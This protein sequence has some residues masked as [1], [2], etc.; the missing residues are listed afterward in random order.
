MRVYWY[1]NGN[2][3]KATGASIFAESEDSDIIEFKLPMA[4]VDSVVHATF[5]LPYP[6]NSEQFGH[7][8]AESLL[9]HVEEDEIDG[10]YVWRATIPGGY[11]VNNGT[12]YISARVESNDLLVVETTEQVQFEI[13][14]GGTYEATAVLPEQAEQINAHLAT[15]DATLLEIQG[16]ISDLEGEISTKQDKHDETLETTSKDVVGA[17]NGLNDDIRHAG[18]GILARLTAAETDIDNIEAEQVTQNAGIRANTDAIN[19]TAQTKG[20]LERVGDLENTAV[21]GET[22]IATKTGSALPTSQQL[23]A[24]VEEIAERDPKGGDYFYFIQQITGGTDKNYKYT[25][26]SVSGWSQAVEI[27]SIEPAGNDTLGIIKGNYTGDTTRNFQ[28]NVVNGEFQSVNVV[29]NDGTLREIRE[30]V[31]S[32]ESALADNIDQ[33]TTNKENIAQNT[34]DIETI[35]GEVDDILDGT[36]E[37]PKATKA[38]QDGN[39]NNIVDTYMTK[40]EGTTKQFVKDYAVP[41]IFN[42]VYF[43]SQNGYV[44]EVP[45]TPASGVQFSVTT[46]AVDDFVLFQIQHQN[47]A[48]FELSAKNSSQNNIFISANV[49]ANVYF[50][51]TT[52]ALVDNQ[53]KTLSIELS[54]LKQMVA[55]EIHKI[56]FSSSFIS[57]GSEVITFVDGAFIRQTLEVVTQSSATTTF[58]VYSNET[59]PSSFN[60]NIQSETLVVSEAATKVNINGIYTPVVNFTEDPQTQI[61]RNR[62]SITALET[63]K[64][65]VIDSTHKLSA[66]L[67]D[68]TNTT[69][70]FVTASDKTMWNGKQDALSTAQLAAVNS[71]ADATKI[72]QIATNAN[73]IDAIEALIPSQATANNQLA[74]KAFVNSTVQTGTANFRGNWVTWADVPTQASDYPLDY[75]QSRT[76]TVNDYL[77]VQDASGYP[78][79]TLEGT[80]RFK[81]SGDWTTNGKNGWHPEYQ[82]NET[83]FTS[84]QLDAINSGATSALIGQ[85]T[86]NQNAITGLGTSKQDVIDASHKLSA[87]LVDDTNT[88]NLFVTSSEKTTWSG[89]QDA[90]T[91]DSSP[92]QNSANPVT[93]GGVYTALAAKADDNAVVKLTGNQTVAG[94]KTFSSPIRGSLQYKDGGGEY[95]NLISGNG[96]NININEGDYEGI[97]DVKIWGKNLFFND[98]CIGDTYHK[99]STPKSA[100]TTSA[101]TTTWNVSDIIPAADYVSGAVYELYGQW[102]M[103]KSDAAFGYIWTDLWGN[104]TPSSGAVLNTTGASRVAQ[105]AFTIPAS[106]GSAINF[107]R[108]ASVSESYIYIFG[109]RRIK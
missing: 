85:I 62:Q 71:G 49:N 101:S 84:A 107:K 38:T 61:S 2:F 15:I 55:G 36:T 79:D 35:E 25:Y 76:P 100:T 72:G 70:K 23:T 63:S 60:L 64:Q 11:L 14:P 92:T 53:W 27:P 65:D 51:M 28:V 6:Q 104:S 77:V 106:A 83:P 91:F 47:S 46:A 52:E 45:T 105:T 4:R 48:D 69:N 19:G 74:D 67:V 3:E 58:N 94:I 34:S 44:T 54:D 12:A 42:D 29:D 10:G 86:T 13:Q 97:Q 81:Y 102:H 26:S 16:D 87:D 17:I 7:Y 98:N 57:L 93:S 39:G 37:V 103:Y 40:Q 82:V 73:D 33:T 108:S 9:M 32:I 66:D 90:L 99:L 43:V 41:R 31:N 30:Y 5:L 8:I 68:D 95:A 50:R 89:K 80:W 20:L 96:T 18:T 75:A 78:L 1:A 109:Y 22:Y 56:S 21:T 88:T 24:W 59:Y